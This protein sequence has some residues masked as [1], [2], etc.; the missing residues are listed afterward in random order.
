MK[1]PGHARRIVEAKGKGGGTYLGLCGGGL[2][3]TVGGGTKGSTR[4]VLTGADASSLGQVLLTLGLAD[5]DLLLLAAAAE[6]L[7]LEGV[8]R[9]ELSAAMLGDVALSHGD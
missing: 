8:L 9:L 2:I 4:S 6:L 1:Y 7:R 3:V 5:L